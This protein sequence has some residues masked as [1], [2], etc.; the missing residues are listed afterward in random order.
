MEAYG[1][2]LGKEKPGGG[3]GLSTAAVKMTLFQ[4]KGNGGRLMSQKFSIYHSYSKLG[5][6]HK[7]GCKT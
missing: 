7:L 3:G 1:L 5:D 2:E 4:F 6:D